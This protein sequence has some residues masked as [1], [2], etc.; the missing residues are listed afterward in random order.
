MAVAAVADIR[1]LLRYRRRLLRREEGAEPLHIQWNAATDAVEVVNY[2]AGEQTG[3]TAHAQVLDID[4]SV[5]WEKSA[6][7]DS[8]EDSTASPIQLEFPAG[9]ART[10]FIRLTLARG[11]EIV[12]SNFYLHGLTEGDYQGIR[13][14]ASAKVDAKTNDQTGPVHNG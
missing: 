4:G 8:R 13:D 5:K 11:R 6:A 1:L 10:H 7:I 9:L 2:S 3:L 14:L 12:S